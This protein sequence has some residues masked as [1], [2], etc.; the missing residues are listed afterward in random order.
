MMAGIMNKIVVAKLGHDKIPE[1]TLF[2]TPNKYP[3][4]STWGLEDKS[5]TGTTQ[6]DTTG[7]HHVL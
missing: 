2:P 5:Q 3:A 1:E 4:Q 6:T 7:Q